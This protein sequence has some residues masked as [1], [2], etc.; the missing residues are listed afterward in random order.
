MATAKVPQARNQKPQSSNGFLLLAVKILLVLLILF[1]LPKLVEGKGRG[2]FKKK[3]RRRRTE[4]IFYDTRQ[5][6]EMETCVGMIPEESMNCVQLCISPA[7]YQEV[8]GDVPL[9]DGE[10]DIDRARQFEVCVK[11]E[12]RLARKR[13]RANPSL[14]EI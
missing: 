11:E 1:L 8:Y 10:I 2:R 13:Q 14:Y 4:V 7:C 3:N 12:M 5:I 6:C 9:E